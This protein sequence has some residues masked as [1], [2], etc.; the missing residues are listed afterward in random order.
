MVVRLLAPAGPAQVPSQTDAGVS[1]PDR[2][3]PPAH[4]DIPSPLPPTPAPD[5]FP[6]ARAAS[7]HAAPKSPNPAPAKL[8]PPPTQARRPDPRRDRPAPVAV[9][10]KASDSRDDGPT[11][12]PAPVAPSP[13][14]A[15]SATVSA[16]HSPRHSAAEAAASA[17]VARASQGA[18]LP[19]TEARF[20][21]AYLSNPA[22]TYPR[23]SRRRG[24]E[25]RVLLRVRVLADGAAGVVEIAEGS[26]HP[27]LDDAA[28]ETVKNWRFV[29]ASKG[30]VKMESW[31][32]VPI[33]FRLED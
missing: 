25:G 24:E 28:R 1:E 13:S 15:E 26:G 21:A 12:E 8:A 4:D 14:A 6:P 9:E 20:D 19:I 16:S 10:E 31:L 22:P 2:V 23:I 11:A 18:S 17:P 5:A 7:A 33:V 29:P 3:A 27:R 30:E 32:N